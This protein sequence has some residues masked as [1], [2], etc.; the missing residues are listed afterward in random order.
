VNDDIVVVVVFVV[1]EAQELWCGRCVISTYD[2]I[3]I[4]I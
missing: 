3:S 1:D 2:N 4:Y